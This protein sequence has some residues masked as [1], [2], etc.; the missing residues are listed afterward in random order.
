[1]TAITLILGLPV[2][3]PDEL[4]RLER[5]STTFANV[6]SGYLLSDMDDIVHLGEYFRGQVAARRGAGGDDLVGPS[7]GTPG[8]TTRTRWSSSE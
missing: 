8:W 7:C 6:T 3:P 1:M 2:P 5:W 4:R